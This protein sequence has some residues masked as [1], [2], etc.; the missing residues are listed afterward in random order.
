MSSTS[1][2][3]HAK[4]V[5]N[6]KTLNE[7][8][9]GFGLPYNP[10]NPLYKVVTMVAQHTAC[11]ALQNAV[12]TQRGIFEPFQNARVIENKDVKKLVRK[13]RTAAK[14]CGASDEFYIDVNK[15]ILKYKLSE[16]YDRK[17]KTKI[18]DIKK[19]NKELIKEITSIKKSKKI[20]GI[21]ID[22]H[23]SHY[24]PRKYV[25]FC[26]VTKCDIKELNKRL[27]RK[28]FNG[29]KIQEN[30]QSEI[31]D[32]CYNEA[33]ER[34]HKVLVVNTAKGFKIQNIVKQLT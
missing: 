21:I 25:D 13:V 29:N 18:V 5:G 2:S 1:E 11:E 8:N 31:F 3:G 22:S 15:F 10:N 14:T 34:R 26:I 4:N 12:N 27:K 33:L 17:R 6:L 28:K 16:G 19:L 7:I 30:L 23:L 20:K 9:A 32:V 24:L